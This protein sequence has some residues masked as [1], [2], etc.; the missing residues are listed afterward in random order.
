M[1]KVEKA[2]DVGAGLVRHK[3]QGE[4]TATQIGTTLTAD[5][6]NNFQKGLIPFV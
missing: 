2:D 3:W 1:Y 5:I 4:Q 6:M